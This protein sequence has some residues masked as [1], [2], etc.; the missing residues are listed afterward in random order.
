M[1][2]AA[3]H[4]SR[5]ELDA[6]LAQ[7]RAAP[8]DEGTLELIV[9]RPD[10]DEREVLETA[11]LDEDLGLVGDSWSMRPTS[12]SPDGG[13]HPDAQLN[14]MSAR[15]IALISPDEARRPLA[16]DQ[17][18]VDLD[19]GTENLPP[20]THL[21]IGD[22]L[23]EVTAKP[24]RGCKKFSARFGPDALRFVNSEVGRALCLRGV[25]ARVVRG[26]TIRRGDVVRKR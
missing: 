7:I 16:G 3:V 4:R 5:A 19:L 18:Y 10:V 20:G 17:L 15:A 13:P 23:I 1:R 24:H 6:G 26:G 12:S 21:A 9:R 22:A 11:Q 25:N 8:R 14:V 2:D